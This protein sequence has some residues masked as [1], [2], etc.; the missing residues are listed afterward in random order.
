MK[1]KASIIVPIHNVE[2]YIGRCIESLLCQTEKNIEIILVNDATPDGCMRI[3]R[4]YEYSDSRIRVIDNQIN[5]GPM[6]VRMQGCKTASGQYIT[7]CDGD[8]ELPPDA[9]EKMVGAMETSGADIVAGQMLYLYKKSKSLI[10]SKLSYGTDKISVYKSL[11]TK[12]MS[13]NLCGKMFKSCLFQNY[14]YKVYKNHTN[15][16]D[17]L[18]LYQIV[19]NISKAHVISDIVY[20]YYQNEGSSTH[21]KFN[22]KQIDNIFTTNEYRISVLS[23]IPELEDYALKLVINTIVNSFYRDRDRVLLNN[24]LTK[25]HLERVATLG[26]ILKYFSIKEAA[27]LIYKKYR[28]FY[29]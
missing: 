19:G 29:R 24:L 28:Y 18:M 23:K 3:V 26:N 1:P 2:K 13:Q 10:R 9:V 20:L 27:I 15:A 6:C 12:D 5:H 11:L 16:E 17:A 7:F 4:E 25:H 8:D 21:R 22:E 14:E